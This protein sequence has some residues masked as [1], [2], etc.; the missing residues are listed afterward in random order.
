[1]L[2]LTVP[3]RLALKGR[4]HALNPTVIIGN[5]GLTES[6]LA[7]IDQ[8]LKRHELIKIRVMG[9]DRELRATFMETICTALHAAPI[10]IIGKI[11]IVYKPNPDADLI[12]IKKMPRHKG[13]RLTK[14]QL[15]SKV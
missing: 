4:A 13:N 10:Q 9:D 5:A 8:T 2:A 6:V 1:M 11:L 12:P 3:E 14:K 15:A 7:E